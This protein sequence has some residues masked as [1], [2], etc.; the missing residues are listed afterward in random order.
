MDDDQLGLW[1]G[2]AYA[3]P[4]CVLFWG[5]VIAAVRALWG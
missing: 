1:R 3:A 5:L 2:L 4:W